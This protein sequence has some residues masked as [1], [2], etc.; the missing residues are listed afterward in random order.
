MYQAILQ[1]N[2][3]LTEADSSLDS[4][5][6]TILAF[7]VTLAVGY[8]TL[9]AGKISGVKLVEGLLALA[10]LS[11]SIVLLLIAIWP[12]KYR[13][14]TVDYF[15]KKEYFLMTNERLSLQ[16]ISDAQYAFNH[17]NDVL[18][19]KVKFYRIAIVLL[20]ITVPVM[21]L[22]RLKVFTLFI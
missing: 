2:T 13:S 16:L 15:K 17:N 3:T 14:V 20:V 5:A 6:A 4:K 7:E 21:G 10:L 19:F 9:V 22:T 18:K 1:K 8:L 12:K 11:V